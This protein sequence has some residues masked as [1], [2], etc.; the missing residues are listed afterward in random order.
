MKIDTRPGTWVRLAG[1]G[2]A[3]VLA[4]DS[5]GK[6]AVSTAEGVLVIVLGELDEDATLRVQRADRAGRRPLRAAS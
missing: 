1:G 4:A 3:E 6:L 5:A 2:E